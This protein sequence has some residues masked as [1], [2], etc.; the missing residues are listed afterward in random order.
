MPHLVLR[1]IK[2]A[3]EMPVSFKTVESDAAVDL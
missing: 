1:R 3:K 2:P